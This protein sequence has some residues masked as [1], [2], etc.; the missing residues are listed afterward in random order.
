MKTN[1]NITLKRNL[2]GFT[3]VELLVVIAI[4]ASLAG[5]S[6]GPIMRHLDSSA[7]TEAISNGK[8][9]FTALTGYMAANEGSFP[10]DAKVTASGG[11]PGTADTYFTL[12]F[13]NGHISDDKYF[14][15]KANE[16]VAVI[17]RLPDND[18]E[19]QP[20]ENC[21][22]YV[23]GLSA[24][25]DR[26]PLIFDASTDGAAFLT[27]TWK[28]KAI[29]IKCDGSA[30]AFDITYTPPLDPA[31]LTQSGTVEVTSGASTVDIMD[32]LYGGTVKAPN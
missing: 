26:A 10:D 2:K 28:G 14:G 4:I 23:E 30:K 17:D 1:K 25:D 5:L 11:T 22:G 27:N 19:L 6:Y 32:E 7:R 9:V 20:E 18:G 31:T 15:N 29:I 16:K 8:N 24:S 3:L 21:W 12:L 13:N